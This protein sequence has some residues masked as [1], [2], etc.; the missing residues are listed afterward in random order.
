MNNYYANKLSAERLKRCYDIAPQRVRQY[1]EAEI[2]FVL[3]NIRSSNQVLELGCGYGRI[4]PWLLTKTNNIIGI[5]NSYSSLHYGK[6]NYSFEK[7]SYFA[8]MD[9]DVLGFYDSVFDVVLCLQNGLSAFKVNRKK[10]VNEAVRVTKSG[11]IVF[12][13][14]YSEKFW[15]HR[16]EWFKIQAAHDL[17]G[18][19]D[20]NE[21][22][23]GVIV[24]KDGFKAVTISGSE[25]DELSSSLNLKSAITEVDGSSLFWIIYV[26]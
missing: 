26:D 2:N 4:F 6:N 14:T 16:L 23:D 12:F 10:L 17:I 21:T 5:D 25:F 22:G 7:R 13:S 1:L 18:E 24:C 8:Q 11:G 9:A 20:Y 3:E 19:I 15:D